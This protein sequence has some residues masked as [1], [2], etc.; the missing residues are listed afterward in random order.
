MILSQREVALLK[1]LYALTAERENLDIQ[2][3]LTMP[4]ER[5]VRIELHATVLTVR[6]EFV[7]APPAVEHYQSIMGV[8][9]AYNVVPSKITP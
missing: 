2:M 8:A 5:R 3:W 7:D 6:E 9:L 4:S 1:G